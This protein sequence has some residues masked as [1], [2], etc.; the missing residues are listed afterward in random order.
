MLSPMTFEAV[1]ADTLR[2]RRA[3]ADQQRLAAL[4]PRRASTTAAARHALASAL[5][6]AA[7]HLD[8]SLVRADSQPAEPRLLVARSR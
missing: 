1:A 2:E 5:R 6:D 7:R 4:L 8:P 3:F